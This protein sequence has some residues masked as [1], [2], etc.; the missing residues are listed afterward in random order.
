MT[1]GLKL[2][3]SVNVVSENEKYYHSVVG[4]LQYLA[5]GTRP[6]ICFAVNLLAIFVGCQSEEHMD[7][8]DKLLKYI[9]FTRNIG[10]E[11]KKTSDESI[12][13]ELYSDADLGGCQKSEDN[14]ETIRDCKSTT[15]YALKLLGCLILFKSRKTKNH[16]EIVNR[17]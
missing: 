15:G 7:A 17:S 8:I 9:N 3:K 6:D 1:P 10:L 4:S 11:F 16:S 5:S 14:S 13:L 12:K 2:G